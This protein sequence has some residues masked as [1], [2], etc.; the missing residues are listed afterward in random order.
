MNK[1]KEQ[2]DDRTIKCPGCDKTIYKN[3]ICNCQREKA[4]LNKLPLGAPDFT[5]PVPPHEKIH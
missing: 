1:S 4:G 2:T 5:K 3:E